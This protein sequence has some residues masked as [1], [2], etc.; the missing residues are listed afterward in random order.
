MKIKSKKFVV[1]AILLVSLLTNSLNTYAQ[2]TEVLTNQSIIDLAKSNVGKDVINNLINSSQCKFEVG[3]KDII[4]L[5]KSGVD[6]EVINYMMAKMSKEKAKENAHEAFDSI[7]KNNP[8]VA[9][10]WKLGFGIY[11]IKP[12]G[13]IVSIDP[14]MFSGENKANTA[15]LYQSPLA[16]LKN[17]MSLSGP[18]AN[19]EV[20]ERR[21]QFVFFFD[22]KLSGISRQLPSWASAATNPQQFTLAKLNVNKHSRE[23][24][25]GTVSSFRTTT[26]INDN[27][28][29][30]FKSSKI[31]DGMYSITFETDLIPTQYCFM[32]SSSLAANAEVNPQVY[33]FGVKK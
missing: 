7:A 23:I 5:G 29:V 26:G 31:A 28:K 33:D 12:D 30:S 27:E 16:R 22:K 18:S 2:D 1:L 3:A 17:K 11:Y 21:P 4:N 13:T 32:F 8:V 10:I 19:L 24:V 20:T 14:S 25:V 15:L 9:E 6:G